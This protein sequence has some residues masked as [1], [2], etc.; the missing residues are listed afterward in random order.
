MIFAFDCD[1]TICTK[2]ERADYT[3]AQPIQDMI[4]IINHLYDDGHIIKIYTARGQTTGISQEE[5]T[6]KQLKKFGVK[7]HEL[8]MDK[9]YYDL[10]I[11]DKSITPSGFKNLYDTIGINEVPIL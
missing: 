4:D 10:L 9:I 2:V 5:F 11:D 1:G 7:Y 3:Q 6:R 8:V